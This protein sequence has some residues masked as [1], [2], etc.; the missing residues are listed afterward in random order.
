VEDC[1]ATVP[2]IQHMVGVTSDVSPGNT[3]HGRHSVGDDRVGRQAKNSLSPFP[4][5]Y[6]R[7]CAVFVES[8]LFAAGLQVPITIQPR[9]LN[10]QT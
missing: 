8:V 2:T 9:V 10:E 1:G 4:L 7:N 6:V 3:R 5:L